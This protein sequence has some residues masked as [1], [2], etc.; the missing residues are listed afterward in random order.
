MCLHGRNL[1]HRSAAFL[2][3]SAALAFLQPCGMSGQTVAP[4]PSHEVHPD[5]TI[6][7]RY[8]NTGAKQVQVAISALKTPIAM[9]EGEGIWSATTPPLPPEIYWYSFLVDGQ[10][11][12]DPV[13]GLVLPNYIYFNSFVVVRGPAPQ[14]WE[15][16]DVPHGELHHHFYKSRYTSGV[17]GE[18]REDYLYSAPNYSLST[19]HRDY[20]VYTPPGYDPKNSQR[21][22]VLYLMHGYSQTA[23]DW[24]V[25][26]GAN[27]ILDY[28][29]A[30]GK[31]SPMI[32]VMPLC[33]GFAV[34][35]CSNAVLNEILPAVESEYS[36][37]KDRNDRAIAGLSLGAAETLY[38]A[39]NHPGLFAWVGSF[40]SGDTHQLP[41]P[42]SMD[43]TR[44]NFRLLWVACG[45]DDNFL[46]VN[47]QFIADLRGKSFAVTA[48]QTPGGHE[49]T[50]W[51]NNLIHFV[52]LLFQ[53]N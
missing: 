46:P 33:Y 26:G 6:T 28:L 19:G 29:I 3:L 21:Y 22:P 27:F 38:I 52:P 35:D 17:A 51:H 1:V 32:A 13:N 53:K 31:T 40:S 20:Y 12:L 44:T 5:G 2:V 9:T 7:F 45:A 16:T 49:W 37:L 23:A 24:T 48:I 18:H 43:P 8:R 42:L 14:P 30:Q 15:A 25:P 4:L 10:P 39:F 34:D 47:Q 50:A 36:V 41:H 11:Q